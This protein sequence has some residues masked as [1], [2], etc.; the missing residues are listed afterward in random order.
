MTFFVETC[1][2][3]INI[4]I[5]AAIASDILERFGRQYREIEWYLS[6]IKPFYWPMA[7]VYIWD[8]VNSDVAIWLKATTILGIFLVWSYIK[9]DRDD[10]WKRRKK[11]LLEKVSV[12]GGRLAITPA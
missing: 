2:W 11:K 10:R 7:I 8:V 5:W 4:A 3:L 12:I 6:E 1:G 9:K